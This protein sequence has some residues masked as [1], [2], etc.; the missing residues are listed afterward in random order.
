MAVAEDSKGP[1]G[2]AQL[3]VVGPTQLGYALSAFTVFSYCHYD[4]FIYLEHVKWLQCDG[5]AMRVVGVWVEVVNMCVD[6]GSQPVDAFYTV[7]S[8]ATTPT[9]SVGCPTQQ[10]AVSAADSNE[11]YSIT[12]SFRQ[13]HV[14]RLWCI[15]RHE[16]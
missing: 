9:S 11:L 16:A 2:V 5:P 13:G 3:W 7:V 4:V 12:M 6:G 15:S 14:T 1:M 10:P 8:Y